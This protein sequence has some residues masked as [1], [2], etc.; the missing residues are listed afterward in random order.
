MQT[1]CMDKIN[2]HT[3][4][5]VF[6]LHTHPAATYLHRYTIF[7]SKTAKQ[8]PLYNGPANTH[9]YTEKRSV[10]HIASEEAKAK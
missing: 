2:T 3:L 1:Y 8:P 6:F 9:S 10:T 5:L 4:T 7:F